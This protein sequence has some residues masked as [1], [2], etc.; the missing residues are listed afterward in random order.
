M[1]NLYRENSFKV[2]GTLLSANVQTGNRKS[3]GAGF[4]TTTAIVKSNIGGKD[5]EYEIT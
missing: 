4:V 3:D 5:K 2:V 1:G